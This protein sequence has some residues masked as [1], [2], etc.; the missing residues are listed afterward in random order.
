[1]T[2]RLGLAA[3][4]L[5]ACLL[6]T[7]PLPAAT[8]SST[9][10]IAKNIDDI[11]SLD[12]GEAY[13]ASGGE[14][15]T[16]V[17]DRLVRFEAE[18]V[19]KLVGGVAESWTI[20]E[21]GKTFTFKLRPGLTFQNGDPVTAEDVAFSLQRVVLL[22]KT[23][24][25]LL[26]QFGWTKDNVKDL[27]KAQDPS[28]FV[29][30]LAAD[31]APSLVLNV[32]SSTIGSVIN[33][34]VAMEHETDGDLGNAWLKSNSAASGAYALKSWTPNE[35]VVLEAN[36]SF[37]LGA[38]KLAR[39]VV[40]H[41]PE[42]AAQR[43]LLE[44]GD[45]DIAR[46]LTAD[47]LAGLSGNAHV[48]ITSQGSADTFYVALNQ[49]DER[50]KN[51]KVREALKWLVD[52]DGMAGSFLRGQ[53]KVHQS[54]LPSAFWS[55]IPDNPYKLDVAKAKALLAEAGYPDGFKIEMDAFNS[56]PWTNIAQSIQSTMAEAGV[57]ISILSA[58]QKQVWT[59]YR[60]RQHQM[61]LIQWSPDYL[62]PH[63]NAETFCRNLDN[64]A[65]SKARTVAWRN[66]WF[67]PELSKL[68]DEASRE[69]DTAKREQD[70]VALQKA[71]LADGPY[72]VMFEPTFQVAM[73]KDVENFVM[74]PYW[75]L[76]FYRLATK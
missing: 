7:S 55:S 74:G 38:P 58:E 64:S 73:R 14:I 53:F 32:V 17:Y 69:R 51:P 61:L 76:V 25:F 44:K 21:D 46:N 59:R 27:V 19:S 40:R 52:Y 66:S 47:Q 28:T 37:H 24:S 62:D 35:S 71:V 50:L 1:M 10:V 20:S 34:K 5:V 31:F 23:P 30:T 26:T 9:L 22:D 15:I 60:A 63:S 33:K 43:L 6:P 12:P 18:D 42:A 39:V 67:I 49:S 57:D 72:V 41:V 4:L 36:P 13:E 75:D 56:A 65:D 3:T 48:K 45:I 11:I 2:G 16:N 29:F 70:Y 68:T 8:P 54:F